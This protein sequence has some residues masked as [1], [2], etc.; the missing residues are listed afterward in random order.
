MIDFIKS[1][2]NKENDEEL[3]VFNVTHTICVIGMILVCVIVKL[4]FDNP[5]SIYLSFAISALFLLTMA[6]ANRTHKLKPAI[7]F[8]SIVF[9][10]VYMPEMYY[11]FNRSIS[12]MPV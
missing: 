7:I 3:Y 8:I 2:Y 11:L 5:N 9:N 10:F 1:L 6:E 12:V 4:F